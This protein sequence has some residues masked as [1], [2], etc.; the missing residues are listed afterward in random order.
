MPQIKTLAT[1]L[2]ITATGAGDAVRLN[3]TPFNGGHGREALLHMQAPVGGAGVIRLE[4]HAKAGA[5]APAA[6]DAGWYT[7]ATLNST[8]PL[9]Q[10]IPDLPAW[11]RLNV[12][13][14]GTGTITVKLEGT[15]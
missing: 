5:G 6:G 3:V 10:E 12:A 11:V 14:A 2:S 13:T 8:S 7:V 15:P 4:G 1:A 9:L